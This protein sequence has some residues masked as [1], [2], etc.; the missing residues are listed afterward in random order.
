MK[1]WILAGA[2]LLLA[3]CDTGS[4]SPP[5]STTRAAPIHWVEVAEVEE[6]SLALAVQRSGTL[7]ALRS[8]QILS[9]EEGVITALPFYPGD[10]VE[11]GALLLSL[12]DRLL[13]AQRRRVSAELSQAQQDLQRAR[14][15]SE[16]NLIAVEER[17]RRETE[18][19]VLQ[20]EFE[21]LDA[22]L[23]YTRISAPFTGVIS[24]RLSEP[25]T[26]VA[27][28]THVLS[29]M[30]PSS[31]LIDLNLS[32]QLLQTLQ[33]GDAVQVQID[34]LGSTEHL[35]RV[36]RIYP[37]IDPRT[38]LGRVEIS[39][40]PLPEGARVG[41]F[42]RVRI[43]AATQPRRVIPFAALRQGEST[44]VFVLNAASEVELRPVTTGLRLAD[45]I[46]VLSGLEPGEQVVVRGFFGLRPGQKVSL[47][48]R[49]NRMVEDE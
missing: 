44:Q 22:R 12:D 6:R 25:N 1:R 40:D 24:E 14:T 41:Q 17:Q 32:E 39:L 23:S 48:S 13:R 8:A 11:E 3:G 19:S 18:L 47:S 27:R 26:F 37:E 38:R 20:A 4:G 33:R 7:R 46:E 45:Q 10:R 43:E 35:G 28:N 31:L 42:A 15:L 49:H 5:V 16:R 36:T 2:L 9:Q 29:L 34:A 30:D 21:L